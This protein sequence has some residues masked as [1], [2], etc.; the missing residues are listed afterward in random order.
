MWNNTRHIIIDP[1]KYSLCATLHSHQQPGGVRR[2][3]LGRCSVAAEWDGSLCR[4]HGMATEDMKTSTKKC[5]PDL[6]IWT[7]NC[8][9]ILYTGGGTQ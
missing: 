5:Y 1:S 7:D 9:L 3:L 6:F 4:L 2:P 8:R